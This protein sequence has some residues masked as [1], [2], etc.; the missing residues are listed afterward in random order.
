MANNGSNQFTLLPSGFIGI[1]TATPNHPLSFP[2]TPGNKISLSGTAGNHFGFGLGA[3]LLQIFADAA[4][5]NIGFGYGNSTSFSEL[6]RM[7]GTGRFGIGT[8]APTAML[9]VVR[10]TA[11]DGNLVLRGTTNNTYFNQ[12]TNE[13]TTINGGKN[14]S[15]I[16]LNVAA[17]T[18][19]VGIGIAAPTQKLD[20]NGSVNIS[21]GLAVGIGITV[22]AGVAVGA[23]LAVGGAVGIGTP[24]PKKC[25][26]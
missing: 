14:G 3:G 16:L 19:N 9:D 23:G 8:T 7:T 12:S 21:G 22:A 26:T 20:V 15:N 4:S 11:P 1:G 17:G 25:S 2:N 5:S 6:M 10:G 24:T 18:G 13:H